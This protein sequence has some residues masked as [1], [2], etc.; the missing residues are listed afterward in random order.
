[1]IR[2][3]HGR[4]ALEAQPDREQFLDDVVVQVAGDAVAV[5]EQHH[6]LFGRARVGEFERDA[7]VIGEAGGH[8]QVDRR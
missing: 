1:M 2:A 7:R 4:R 6:P 8:V 5:L 3:D